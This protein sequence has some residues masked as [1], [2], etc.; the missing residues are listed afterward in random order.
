CKHLLIDWRL[1][2]AYFA[3][4]ACLTMREATEWVELINVGANRLCSPDN[5]VAEFS[6]ILEAKLEFPELFGDG[7]AAEIIA[8]KIQ[9][10][11]EGN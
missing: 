9:F 5:L 1:G 7:H 11:L 4:K 2:E 3:K 8:Q 10:F 6:K